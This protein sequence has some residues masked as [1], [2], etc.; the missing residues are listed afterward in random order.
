MTSQV[1][2][3]CGKRAASRPIKVRSGKEMTLWHCGA[4]NFDFFAHDPTAA[5]AADKL[6]ESR[7]KA[8]GLDIPPVE[9]DFAN[10]LRQSEPYVAEYLDASDR[11]R[12]VLEVGC[13]WGYFLKLARDAGAKPYGVE[14]NTVRAN[15]VNTQVGIPCDTSLDACEG[16]G[17]RFKKIFLFYV[18]EYVPQPVAYVQRLVNMLDK[19]GALIML[20]PSLTDPLK[21]LWKNEGFA[22]FF[23][24]EHA[25]N[26]LSPESVKQMVARL[27][28][29]KS[30]VTTR[31]GYSF[32]NHV[33]WFLTGA[34]R[35]TGVVGGDNFVREILA[36]LR[37]AS[38]GGGGTHPRGDAKAAAHLA[39]LIQEFDA[40]YKSYLERRQLGNQI[41]IVIRK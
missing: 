26:Y 37:S 23:Y 11:N 32:V 27:R 5:L 33:S 10:G 30:D 31:Q 22:R 34:P 38:D 9:K 3:I 12:N 35:T 16:R 41:R 14:V 21:D 6:D 40:S 7:L 2:P 19:D 36:A 15:Y 25:I 4:C 28:A 8:A 18:L 24:D 20:T 39:Q 13:S 29:G 17:I 1:C